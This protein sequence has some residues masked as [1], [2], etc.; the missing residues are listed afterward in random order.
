MEF[1]TVKYENS[2][3]P[4]VPI[5]GISYQM[6]AGETRWDGT[7]LAQ[8]IDVNCGSVKIRWNLDS[9]Y[10]LSQSSHTKI[11]ITTEAK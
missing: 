2:E 3:S 4:L 7:W 9:F 6:L 5:V 10:G 8:P 1:Q 11:S